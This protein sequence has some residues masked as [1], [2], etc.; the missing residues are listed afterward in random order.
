MLSLSSCNDGYLESTI[1]LIL[2]H[3]NNC[4]NYNRN[5]MYCVQDQYT[6][7]CDLI[8]QYTDV[9]NGETFVSFTSA[10]HDCGSIT[11]QQDRSI[12]VSTKTVRDNHSNDKDGATQTIQATQFRFILQDPQD[13][14]TVSVS[15]L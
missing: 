8:P 14:H 7:D 6:S 11:V 2:N 3:H 12:T 10:T 9:G 1:K 5:F 13:P 4:Y 15:R